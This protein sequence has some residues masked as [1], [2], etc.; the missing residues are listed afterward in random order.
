MYLLDANVFIDA[1]RRYYPFNVCPGFWEWLDVAHAD[2]RVGSIRRVREE[3]VGFGDDL[4]EW[5]NQRSGFFIEPDDAVVASLTQVAVW[6]AGQNY[7]PAA[8]SQFLDSADYYLVSQAHGQRHTV[9]SH[10]RPEPNRVNRIKIPDVCDAFGVSWLSP[11]AV[12]ESEG[13]E[14]VLA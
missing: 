13:V 1:K 6:V 5:A 3:L 12:L 8:Q 9:V 2:G 7:L 14:F 4:S 10:E 11:F